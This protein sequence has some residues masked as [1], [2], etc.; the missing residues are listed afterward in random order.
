MPKTMGTNQVLL[1]MILIYIIE[2]LT[3]CHISCYPNCVV[4][5][6]S[7][8]WVLMGGEQMVVDK[9]INS[10]ISFQLHYSV[11]K[12]CVLLTIIKH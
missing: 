5:Y 2:K 6:F 10:F 12:Y 7:H 11:F 8:Q 1:L 9:Y 4:T 3:Y